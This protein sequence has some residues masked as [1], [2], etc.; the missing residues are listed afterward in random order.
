M[1]ATTY[2][3]TRICGRRSEPHD[4]MTSANLWVIS[5]PDNWAW[6]VKLTTEIEPSPDRVAVES[7]GEEMPEAIKEEFER[8][9]AQAE[10]MGKV[11]AHFI[12]RLG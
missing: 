4:T 3:P 10:Q 6:F 8:E 1:S 2:T 5:Q 9:L 12:G 7:P 11:F